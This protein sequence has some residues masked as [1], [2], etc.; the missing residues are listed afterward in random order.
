MVVALICPDVEVGIY[1]YF[2]Y[3][4]YSGDDYYFEGS[5]EH[6]DEPVVVGAVIQEWVT[7]I[8][9]HG[10]SGQ[11]L[12]QEAMEQTAPLDV[13]NCGL[14]LA[15]ADWNEITFGRCWMVH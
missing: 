10:L 9:F 7:S 8:L 5:R 3:S 11:V 12:A 15:V 13:H 14:E 2:H 1:Y 4:D 6:F